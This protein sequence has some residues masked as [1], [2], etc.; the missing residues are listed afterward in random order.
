MTF[1]DHVQNMNLIQII[2]HFKNNFCTYKIIKQFLGVYNRKFDATP[3]NLSKEQYP[4]LD[5]NLCNGIII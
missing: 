5:N 2:Y 3:Q 1:F 4:Q